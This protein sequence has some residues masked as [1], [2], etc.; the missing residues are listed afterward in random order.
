[1]NKLMGFP[2]LAINHETQLQYQ[3]IISEILG[4]RTQDITG[5]QNVT[6]YVRIKVYWSETFFIIS[7]RENI[8]FVKLLEISFGGEILA[9]FTELYCHV[10]DTFGIVPV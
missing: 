3:F 10:T 9:S 6:V 8:V 5:T 1:M 4:Y 2:V 7:F